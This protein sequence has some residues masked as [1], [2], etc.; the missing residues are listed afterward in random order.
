[1]TT[2][3]EQNAPAGGCRQ[4]RDCP[5]GTASAAA[6]AQRTCEALG[7]CQHPERECTGACEQVPRLPAFKVG[8]GERLYPS[9]SFAQVPV[10]DLL[11]RVLTWCMYFCAVLMV[12]GVS[13][14]LYARWAA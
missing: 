10:N 3:C 4:G 11:D 8:A 12:L 6:L 2:C 1:M 14:Y 13:G 7:I 5:V 9:S